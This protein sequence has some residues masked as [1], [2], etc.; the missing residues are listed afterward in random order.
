MLKEV[1]TDMVAA[2]EVI[3]ETGQMPDTTQR[4]WLLLILLVTPDM[5]KLAVVA[6]E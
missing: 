2:F 4:Y 3:G 6:P 1:A 5:V